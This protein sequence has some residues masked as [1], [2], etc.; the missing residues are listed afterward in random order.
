MT[1]MSVD[2]MIAY[3]MTLDK[4]AVC[5]LTQGKMTAYKITRQKDINVRNGCRQ[6][7]CR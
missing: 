6:N 2:N 3:K 4:M 1:E 5:K 7:D